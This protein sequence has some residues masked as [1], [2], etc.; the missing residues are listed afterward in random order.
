MA[1]IIKRNNN[2]KKTMD[3]VKYLNTIGVKTIAGN[4]LGDLVVEVIVDESKNAYLVRTGMTHPNRDGGDVPVYY[5][6]FCKDNKIFKLAIVKDDSG[7][8]ENYDIVK[9][10]TATII[11][12]PKDIVWSQCK[13]E[14]CEM[15]KE[16]LSVEAYN[17]YGKGMPKECFKSVDIDIVCE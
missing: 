12:I 14:I 5:H 16:A 10:W 4:T 2:F 7:S 13:S 17:S 15:V 9:H 11:E 6:S 8:L 1:F 3:E